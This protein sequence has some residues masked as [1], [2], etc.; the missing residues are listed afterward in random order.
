MRYFQLAENIRPDVE[1]DLMMLPGPPCT[2]GVL[3]IAAAQ[4]DCRP[5]YLVS[6]DPAV[7]P[8][9]ELRRSFDIPAGR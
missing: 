8:I 4:Q 2:T 9:A 1:L 5:I 7:Y 6:N 3:A